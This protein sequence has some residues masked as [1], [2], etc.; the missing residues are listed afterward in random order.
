MSRKIIVDPAEPSKSGAPEGESNGHFDSVEAQFFEQ[1]QDSMLLVADGDYFADQEDPSKGKWFALSRPF[2][3][4][5]AVGGM[6]G[7]VLV[8]V[9]AW[10]MP[11]P[12]ATSEPVA[13]KQSTG[14]SA[15]IALA[16]AASTP[17]PR[18]GEQAGG[19]GEAAAPDSSRTLRDAQPAFARDALQAREHV[20]RLLSA[21]G[22][23]A[24]RKVPS[25]FWSKASSGP[26]PGG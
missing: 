7:A 20:T 22:Q 18:P 9:V 19:I 21:K 2:F 5:L 16:N 3:M 1:G 12:V 14:S 15:S 6:L 8:G 24:R 25:L 23:L 13:L 4:G 11:G 17:A 26:L 10:R